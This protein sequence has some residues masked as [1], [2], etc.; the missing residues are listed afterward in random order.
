M[1][2]KQKEQASKEASGIIFE[3]GA[4]LVPRFGSKQ[5]EDEVYYLYGPILEPIEYVDLIQ[6][7]RYADEDQQ[8]TLHINSPGGDLTTCLALINAIKAS[9]A[10]VITVIDGE[11]QSAG[12]FI[13][14]AGHRKIVAS[15][16][17]WLM[18]HQAGWTYSGKSAEHAN[19]VE[20]TNKIIDPLLDEYAKWLLTPEEMADVKKGI[21]VNIYGGDIAARAEA[22]NEKMRAAAEKA[23]AAAAKKPRKKA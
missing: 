18:I 16:H 2:A 20:I 10:E 7:I 6:A 1:K 9:P 15:T 13:W 5:A 22:H 17:T 14:L 23:E 11:A 12:A 21:D 8:I 3:H 4:P 19:Q